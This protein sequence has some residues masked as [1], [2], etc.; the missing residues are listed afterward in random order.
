MRNFSCYQTREVL[1]RHRTLFSEYR[2]CFKHVDLF[3]FQPSQCPSDQKRDGSQN[4]GSL[5]AQPPDVAGAPTV[6]SHSVT[7]KASN[8]KSWKVDFLFT[9]QP[10]W[11]SC[12]YIFITFS[13]QNHH[14]QV[15][16]I[17]SLHS[18][19]RDMNTLFN[20]IQL[21]DTNIT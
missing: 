10:S 6:S 13:K 20:K 21:C 4:T 3:D 8:F 12:I 17:F 14:G 19:N 15:V 2:D 1:E 16:F 9:A 11:A 7:M 18:Q 5:T